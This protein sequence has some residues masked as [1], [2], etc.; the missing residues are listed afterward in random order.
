M[1]GTP[2]SGGAQPHIIL[3]AHQPPELSEGTVGRFLLLSRLLLKSLNLAEIDGHIGSPL[4]LT[5]ATLSHI[6]EGEDRIAYGIITG[7][8]AIDVGSNEHE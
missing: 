1:L 7:G 5:T 6:I 3:E 2:P 8:A 4:W